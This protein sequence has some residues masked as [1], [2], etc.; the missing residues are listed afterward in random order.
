MA[1]EMHPPFND[2]IFGLVNLIQNPDG[3]CVIPTFKNIK[4]SENS[5][6]LH[7]SSIV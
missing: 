2:H 7:S 1:S 6:V 5:R 3:Y 4:T